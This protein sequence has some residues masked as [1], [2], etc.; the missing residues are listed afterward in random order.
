MVGEKKGIGEGAKIVSQSK[1]T[2]PEGLDIEMESMEQISCIKFTS[3][4]SHLHI[5][6]GLYNSIV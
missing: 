6:F 3:Y 1:H 5:E 2:I 4:I